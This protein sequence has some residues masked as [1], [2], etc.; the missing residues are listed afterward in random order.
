MLPQYMT[1]DGGLGTELADTYG[2]PDIDV[3]V[4]YTTNK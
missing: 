2:H 3:S 4:A 1:L